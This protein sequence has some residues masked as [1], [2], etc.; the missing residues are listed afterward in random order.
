MSVVNNR[1][2]S[3]RRSAMNSES[4]EDMTSNSIRRSRPKRSSPFV[5]DDDRRKLSRLEAM[6][7]PSLQTDTYFNN[8]FDVD[9]DIPHSLA[10]SGQQEQSSFQ[11]PDDFLEPLLPDGTCSV[12]TPAMICMPRSFHEEMAAS[13]RFAQQDCR[14]FWKA[15]D[16]TS[17][18]PEKNFV[19]AGMDHVR[20]HPKF[21]H[22]NATSHKWVLG[23]LAE[24]LDNA[25]DE[26]MNGATLVNVDTVKNPRNGDA[27]LLIED[28]G[29]GMDPDC[30]R[31]CMSLGYSAKSKIA[32]TIGQYGNGF[33]TSTMRLGADVIV[34]SR[35]TGKAG[36]SPTES[37]GLLSYTFLTGTG[38][39]D[40]IVPIV[41]YEIQPFGLR[42]LL[43]SSVDDWNK[44]METIKHWSPYSSEAELLE[45]F[46]GMSYQGTR[47]IVYNLWEDE[48]GSLEL[49]FMANPHDIQVRGA[50]RDEKNIKMAEQFPNSRHYLTYR[51]SLRS[52]ASILYLRLPSKFKIILRGKQVEHHKLSNDL[53]FTEEVTYKPQLRSEQIQKDLAQMKAVVTIGFVKDAKE[54]IDVQGFSVYHKNRLIKPFWR[55]WNVSDTRGRGIM[56]IL[57]A[58]FVE[59]AHD[60]QGFERTI[61]LTRLETRLI[62]MQKNYWSRNCHKVGYINKS[63]KKDGRL[64]PRKDD[65]AMVGP[66][67]EKSQNN[68]P[69]AL[70]FIQDLEVVASVPSAVTVTQSSAPTTLELHRE[71]CLAL[72][73][74]PSNEPQ[75][76][77][78]CAAQMQENMSSTRSVN[79]I[80]VTAGQSNH[81]EM[82]SVEQSMSVK[83]KALS[84]RAM[85]ACG[86]RSP[87]IDEATRKRATTWTGS[88][89]IINLDPPSP[90]ITNSD[91]VGA[92][93]AEHTATVE[94]E[95][96]AL[97]MISSPEVAL[98]PTTSNVIVEQTC[99]VP[100]AGVDESGIK[101]P[102]A[103]SPACNSNAHEVHAVSSTTEPS[104]P[105][106]SLPQ[107]NALPSESLM[108]E[109][110][111]AVVDP[112]FVEK[113]VDVPS[114]VCNATEFS[115]SKNLNLLEKDSQMMHKTLGK[116]GQMFTNKAATSN[117]E[118]QRESMINTCIDFG[119]DSGVAKAMPLE[120]FCSNGS[121]DIKE[122]KSH[123]S[124][125][126]EE[127]QFLRKSIKAVMEE[128]DKLREQLRKEHQ[129][130]DA[131]MA[132]L[133]KQLDRTRLHLKKL[134]AENGTIQ[135]HCIV[136]A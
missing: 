105:Q 27:M 126:E 116:L 20:V 11:L 136:E 100:A 12:D 73:D 56:G 19:A 65:L 40:I 24:L 29:G 34:F 58:N 47:I 50:N 75:F 91:P 83:E 71:S 110:D 3:G 102:E 120:E 35:C 94:S 99:A 26:V 36:S 123:L 54:H 4:G 25:F 21:L 132:D 69:H 117:N 93:A 30:M 88:A 43:R 131:E 135:P 134:K 44:N 14:Q 84:P 112:S 114:D 95:I 106:E 23:A 37:I 68:I 32:N 2:R 133:K 90:E 52:Y 118:E 42:K 7:D 62:E 128:S 53:M 76:D 17:L 97:K 129:L 70:D 122:L 115:P 109:I 72:T 41:D 74:S 6:V 8:A 9:E 22:S 59:P 1:S 77:S 67:L 28:D 49:D 45:Q 89:E 124:H 92:R 78:E 33:K 48:Q 113:V 82:A 10:S 80:L 18:R 60:K 46:K 13:G 96:C 87:T 61:V 107:S 111:E 125:V 127:V 101:I 104:A 130:A 15:G 85:T 103:T 39:D 98:S 51:H 108:L 119:Q 31:R 57:E 16:Y 79:Q 63:L 66:G 86:S 38:Q 81:S 55:I 5:Y 121:S 64:I